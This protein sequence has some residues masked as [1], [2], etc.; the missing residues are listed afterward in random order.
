MGGKNFTNAPQVVHWGPNRID[1]LGREGGKEGSYVYKYWDGSQWS[2]WEEKV[3]KFASEPALVALAE[4]SLSLFGIDPAG[5][6]LLQVWDGSQWLPST[7]TWYEL[8]DTSSASKSQF[9]TAQRANS[10]FFREREGI[11][12]TDYELKM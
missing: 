5:K 2:G 10:R 7:T 11:Q 6:V 1:I 8:G 9:L 4:N 3:G 12:R